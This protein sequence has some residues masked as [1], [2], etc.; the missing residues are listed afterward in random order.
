MVSKDESRHWKKGEEEEFEPLEK[1][2]SGREKELKKGS[3]SGR[4][5]KKSKENEI[6]CRREF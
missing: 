3:R 2:D 1:K 6:V 5:E 4:V